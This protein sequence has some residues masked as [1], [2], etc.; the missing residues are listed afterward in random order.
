MQN[1]KEF[2]IFLSNIN[3]MYKVYLTLKLID[4]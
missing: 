3:A 4:Y 1:K 2:F